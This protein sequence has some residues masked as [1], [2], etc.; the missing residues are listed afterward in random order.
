MTIEQTLYDAI[1]N[2]ATVSA[3]AGTKIYPNVVPDNV[4]APYISYQLIAGTAYNKL[5][6]VPDGEHK[7]MQV[8]CMSKSYSQVKAME[9]AVKSALDVSIGYLMSSS[10]G[11]YTSTETH[12]VR[13]DFALIG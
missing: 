8:N 6:G 2:D 1:R 13:L 10:D 7:L 5:D 3:I 4:D 12:V 9:D 11:Y